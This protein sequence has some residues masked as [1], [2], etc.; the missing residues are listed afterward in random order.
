MLNDDKRQTTIFDVCSNRHGGNENSLEA[1]K[2]TNAEQDRRRILA[3]IQSQGAEGATA[4]QI[5]LALG[6]IMNTVSG[7]CTELKAAGLVDTAGKRPTRTGS[8]ASV[9]VATVKVRSNWVDD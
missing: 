3:Y 1:R 6:I 8:P 7:R 9:L 2:R 5:S 4:D